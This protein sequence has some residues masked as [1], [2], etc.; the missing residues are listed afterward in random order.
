MIKKSHI[1]IIKN[2][3]I[4]FEKQYSLINRST[5][6]CYTCK[7]DDFL[8]I[9][10]KDKYG[11]FYPVVICKNCSLIQV[12]PYYNGQEIN[13]FY[14]KYFR[15]IYMG[16]SKISE[17][18]FWHNVKRGDQI[19]SYIENKT[20][21]EVKNKNILDIGCGSGAMSMAFQKKNNKC[22]GIDL[23]DDYF[24]Q[25]IKNNLDLRKGSLSEF[26]ELN[27]EYKADIVIFSDNLEHLIDPVKELKILKKIIHKETLV[28]ISVPGIFNMENSHYDILNEYYQNAHKFHF[29]LNS[30]NKLMSN[31][32]FTNIHGDESIYA[33]FKLSDKEEKIILEDYKKIIKKL[34]SYGD[35][36]LKNK[37]KINFLRTTYFIMNKFHIKIVF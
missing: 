29:T 4:E 36:Y 5:E 20:K 32:G 30:L 21:I 16:E 17:K 13:I 19:I 22:I 11:F 14:R 25:G 9:S 6:K 15:K 31:G 10:E 34:E 26:Y 33:I 2:K 12:N 37:L 8:K 23:G 3:I 24:D 27:K 1:S 35:I 18:K 28:F 7:S